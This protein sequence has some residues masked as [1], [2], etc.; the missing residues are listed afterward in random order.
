MKKVY[1]FVTQNV[2][3]EGH[4]QTLVDVYD[5]YD[6]AKAHADSNADA[7]KMIEGD[8]VKS[9]FEFEGSQNCPTV[10]GFE[11]QD[12]IY[13]VETNTEFRGR[14]CTTYRAVFSTNIL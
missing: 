3:E 11:F 13:V 12:A 14:K 7:Q 2:N 4:V 1:L 6:K 10:P 5:D 8:C 9:Q